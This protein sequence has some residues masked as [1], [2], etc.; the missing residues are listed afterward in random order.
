[1]QWFR[2]NEV[3]LLHFLQQSPQGAF[4]VGFC[5]RNGFLYPTLDGKVLPGT[6][7]L[8]LK[9]LVPGGLTVGRNTNVTVIHNLIML[10][11][12]TKFGNFL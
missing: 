4:V 9:L 1:M 8:N 10:S 3:S 6:I 5:A 2:I 7:L 11:T 12:V